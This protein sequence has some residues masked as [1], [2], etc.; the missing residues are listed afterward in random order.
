MLAGAEVLEG[1]DPPPPSPGR[2][3]LTR[4]AVALAVLAA[5]AVL[6]ARALTDRPPPDGDGAP[7][8][9]PLVELDK[10]PAGPADAARLLLADGRGATWA[11]TPQGWVVRLDATTPPVPSAGPPADPSTDRP[12]YLPAALSA[13]LSADGRLLASAGSSGVELART[14][15]GERALPLPGEPDRE[16]TVAVSADGGLVAVVTVATATRADLTVLDRD[17]QVRRA[18]ALTGFGSPVGASFSDD[19]RRIVVAGD[20]GVGTVD[21]NTG[22]VTGPLA[23]SSP[24]HRMRWSW[25][26]GWAA[27]PDGSR[28]VLPGERVVWHELDATTGRILSRFTRPPVDVLLGWTVDGLLVWW[29]PG[30]I[31][32]AGRVL[33]RAPDGSRERVVVEVAD[34]AT[35]VRRALYA[36]GV[37]A[38]A[39]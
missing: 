20:G 21:L 9:V 27:S 8:R 2:R 16:R 6:G 35:C 32:C 7:A 18:V 37:P 30:P 15:G 10:A 19:G 5:A 13:A 29:R 28:V 31:G 33:A 1:Y 38:L 39:G 23:V 36:T 22:E 25:D 26:R 14:D 34:G 11:V 3:R 24:W 4:A 12:A 17:G